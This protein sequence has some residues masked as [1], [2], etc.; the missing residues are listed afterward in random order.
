MRDNHRTS[1]NNNNGD[2]EFDNNYDEHDENQGD[3]YNLRP[4][5]VDNSA[6]IEET[7]R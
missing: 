3:D 2:I 4:N 7:M 1:F 5:I 6:D